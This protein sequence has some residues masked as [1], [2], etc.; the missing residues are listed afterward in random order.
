M[1]GL[2]SLGS[3]NLPHDVIYFMGLVCNK[4]DKIVRFD[5]LKGGSFHQK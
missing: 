4:N 3:R 2:E 5:I 1:R